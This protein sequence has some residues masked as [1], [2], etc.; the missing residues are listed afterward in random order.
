MDSELEKLL[1]NPDGLSALRQLGI[2]SDGETA[3]ILFGHSIELYC[4]DGST[5][6]KRKLMV[7]LIADYEKELRGK[8]THYHPRD[9]RRLKKIYG[10]NWVE[11]FSNLADTVKPDDDE[12]FDATVYGFVGGEDEDT[13]T[14]YFCCVIGA[15]DYERYSE[16][17][18][19]F[20]I[21]WFER[22]DGYEACIDLMKRWCTLLTVSHGTAGFSIILEE[23][24]PKSHGV[25]LAYPFLKRF[26]GLDLPYSSRWGSSIRG[27]KRRV[28]RSTNWLTA[29]DDGFVDQLGGLKKIKN[30]LGEHC[31]IHLY[32]G[33]VIIQAG[34]RPEIG[35]VNR[36]LIPEHYRTVAKLLKPLRFEDFSAKLPYLP[37]PKP[38]DSLEETL[39]WIR[40]FD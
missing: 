31:P 7:D 13:A 39:K 27:V 32:G 8:I 2:T 19:Y 22:R 9:S 1:Q 26:P 30:E 11:Y 20:P 16:A 23:G 6:E 28:I 15:P 4:E 10:S 24:Q 36:G 17:R 12:G 34:P 3:D 37:A 29:I 18:S 14:P 35:D 25:L 33:G 21:D 40:R 5:V 38:M